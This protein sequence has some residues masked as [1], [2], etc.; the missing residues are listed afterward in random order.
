MRRQQCNAISTLAVP[1]WVAL[2]AVLLLAASHASAQDAPAQ[3]AA[4]DAGA[5][6][7]P[8][9]DDSDAIGFGA[10]SAADAAGFGSAPAATSTSTPA[11]TEDAD[12]EPGTLDAAGYLAHRLALWSK[13]FSSEPLAQSR[14]TADLAL[15]YKKPFHLGDSR[16]LL[17]LVGEGLVEYDFAYLHDPERFD[18]ATIDTYRFH[19]IGR[20]TYAAL[21]WGPLELTFG[22][23]IVPFGQG[24]IL[25]PLDIVNPRD[26]REPGLAELEDIRMAV[27]ASRVGLFSGPHRLEALVVHRFVLRTASGA[28]LRLQSATQAAAG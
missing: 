17:R 6:A 21:S 15:R 14:Q 18:Q 3:N 19:V 28:A 1:R 25:S 24:D 13:R 4:P 27:L 9:A 7:A 22:R 12:D 10:D 26:T 5:A 2:G 23:Q 16:L 11:P 8:P 20:E